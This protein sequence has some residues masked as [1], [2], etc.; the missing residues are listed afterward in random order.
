M[1]LF[2]LL[3]VVTALLPAVTNEVNLPPGPF[4]EEVR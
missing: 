2:S 3:A 1:S 4:E